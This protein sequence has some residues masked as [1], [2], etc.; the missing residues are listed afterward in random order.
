MRKSKGPRS[1]VLLEHASEEGRVYRYHTS[2]NRRNTPGRLALR[3]Y[4]PV[5]GRHEEFKEIS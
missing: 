1:Y 2:K 5:T 3:K 4:S